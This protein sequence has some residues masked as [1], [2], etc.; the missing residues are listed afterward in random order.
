[1]KLVTAPHSAPTTVPTTGDSP[2]MLTHTI[3]T[4]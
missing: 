3:M 1:V 4:Q 2:M